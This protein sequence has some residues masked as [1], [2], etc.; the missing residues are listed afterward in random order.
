MEEIKILQ[1]SFQKFE[2]KKKVNEIYFDGQIYD[3]YSLLMK[4]KSSG[5]KPMIII[6]LKKKKQSKKMIWT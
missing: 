1:E 2:E 5:I 4:I 3:A 6:L